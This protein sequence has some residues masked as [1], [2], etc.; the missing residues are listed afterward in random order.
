VQPLSDRWAFTLEGGFNE[1]LL[2]RDNNGRVVA[3]VQFGSFLRPR[4]Y[5]NV[6]H[7]VPADI[8]RIR[9][10][11]LTRR[12][13]T[14][15]SAPVADAG[16]DQIGVAPGQIRLDGSGSSDPDGDPLSF[17]WE[18]IAGPQVSLS[19]PTQAVTTFTAAENQTY[20]FRLIVRDPSGA[21]AID[22]VN[23]TTRG[24]DQV[25]IIRFEANPSFIRAGQ[26][27]TL[28]WEV[29]NAETVEITSLG[30]VDPRAG[31]STV[32]LRETTTFR[33]TARNRLSEANQAITVT[34]DRPQVRIISFTAT[35][36]TI[37]AGEV[38]TLAWQ[39]EN[40]DRAQITT[41]GSVRT[42]GT[43]QVSPTQTTTY[44][45]TA[46]NEFSEVSATVV[47][48]VTGSGEAPRIIRFSALPM[49]IIRGERS[50]LIWL[51]ENATE[52]TI[53]HG[54]GRV[55]LDGSVDVSPTETTTYTITARNSF[56]EASATT[57][58]TIREA[59]TIAKCMAMP[60]MSPRPGAPIAISFEA[61][62][63][64][65]VILQGVGPVTSP[66][67]VNPTMNMTY[68]LTA[69]GERSQAS[70]QVMVT[71]AGSGGPD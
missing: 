13:R 69:I 24:P 14:G 23:V 44:T 38:S 1:T 17:L 37:T 32:T 55:A 2:G 33:I 16:P 25:R 45:L 7:P 6:E 63:A 29:E 59:A 58:V 15:N 39:T 18:Q 22:R 4:D 65:Q 3:G 31:T 54:I 30:R 34:V 42:N 60:M 12:V 19:S 49:S 46:A 71:I 64:T 70:C 21:Q 11:F 48:Q 43:A 51:V 5:L 41:I 62:N 57:T 20:A 56:G 52:V 40:A 68:T 66:V 61:Q 27:T 9:Y 26:T 10:E 8:P 50:T 35:P 53:S 47:V 36:M 67:V 28:V